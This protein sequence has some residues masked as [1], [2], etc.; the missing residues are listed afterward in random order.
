MSNKKQ[1]EFLWDTYVEE[2][3]VDP[4]NL[5]VSADETIV[6]PGPNGMATIRINQGVRDG[7]LEIILYALVGEH[8]PRIQELLEAANSGA[9][10]SLVEDMMEHFNL[11][12]DVV[13][14]GPGGGKVKEKRPTKI[15]RLLDMGYREQGEA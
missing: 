13:L 14:I 3:K 15:K 1:T 4:F 7:D 6:I 12:H 11:Y 9:F 8:W 10:E 5:K 2:A